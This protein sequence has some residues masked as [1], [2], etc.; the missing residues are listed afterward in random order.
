MDLNGGGCLH[1]TLLVLDTLRRLA[2][3]VPETVVQTS[4]VETRVLVSSHGDATTADAVLK[5]L[6]TIEPYMR[7]WWQ[8][9]VGETL[10]HFGPEK[11][12]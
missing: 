11:P 7:G 12:V 8:F 1:T 10:H 4:P 3:L 2:D 5:H 9:H 6:K